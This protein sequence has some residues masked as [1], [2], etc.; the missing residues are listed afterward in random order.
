MDT[1]AVDTGS[2][3]Q[4]APAEAWQQGE[5][6][7]DDDELHHGIRTWEGG[8]LSLQDSGQVG[9]DEFGYS[10]YGYGAHDEWGTP[11]DTDPDMVP[12]RRGEKRRSDSLSGDGFDTPQTPNSPLLQSS[13]LKAR[14]CGT[15]SLFFKTKLCIKFKAGTCPYNS[16]CN[17]AHGMDELRK[18]PLDGK[19]WW[20]IKTWVL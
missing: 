10:S 9:S 12:L 4:R 8:S 16:S 20:E 15:G 11:A 19:T 14:N 1:L 2:F 7:E 17:F 13:S 5:E 6:E 3:W 18:P